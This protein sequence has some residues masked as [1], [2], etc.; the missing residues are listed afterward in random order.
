MIKCLFCNAFKPFDHAEHDT[1]GNEAD[2]EEYGP[3][4]PYGPLIVHQRAN[5]QEEVAYGCGTEPQALTET[6]QV[7]G[8]YL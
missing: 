1:H 2:H 7:F 6:L 5:P 3:A 8:G 4:H